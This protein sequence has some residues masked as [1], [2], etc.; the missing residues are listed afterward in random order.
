MSSGS[1]PL[2]T[3]HRASQL[4]SG[5]YG[6]VVTVYNDDGEQFALKLFENDENDDSSAVPGVIDLGALREIS[7]LRFFRH[8]NSHPN[9]VSMVDV[10]SEFCDDEDEVGAGTDGCLGMA[11]PLFPEGNLLSAISK[12]LVTSRKAKV[13][14]AHGLLS[15]IAHLHGKYSA[16][17]SC[18]PFLKSLLTCLY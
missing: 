16:Q 13:L 7:C 2:G 18:A 11:L 3:Y 10:Q 14:V 12:K 15:A 8:Q 1:L 5:S 4:G 6:S 9:I 17:G